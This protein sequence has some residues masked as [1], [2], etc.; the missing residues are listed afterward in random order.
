MHRLALHHRGCLGLEE[1]SLGGSDGALAVHR[2]TQRVDDPPQQGV[3]HRHR[4]HPA[5]L[6]NRIAL[7]DV[8]GVAHDHGADRVFVEV[9]G[10]PEQPA[11][12]LEQFGCHGAG[13]AGHTGNTVT[14]R[15][16]LANGGGLE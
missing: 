6:T 14:D 4:Q 3:A 12:E 16:H 5:G 8:G 15:E 7:L 1:A 2:G 13:Q 10:H 9:E 11:G